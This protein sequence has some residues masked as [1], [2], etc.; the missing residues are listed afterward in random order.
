MCFKNLGLA[1]GLVVGCIVALPTYGFAAPMKL[2]CQG[3]ILE[4]DREKNEI[5]VTHRSAGGG[6]IATATVL[7]G[8]DKRQ[9][10]AVTKDP[11][12]TNVWVYVLRASGQL[13]FWGLTDSR[14]ADNK[15]NS[16]TDRRYCS[17]EP[18]I[19]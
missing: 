8:T 6:K 13:D 18:R 5:K 17:K 12:S 15:Q 1:F 16:L 9:M 10:W 3:I 4:V 7:P 11:A 14:W 19:W 2:F